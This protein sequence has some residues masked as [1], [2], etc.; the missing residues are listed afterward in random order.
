MRAQRSREDE[1]PFTPGD[2]AWRAV[3][4]AGPSWLVKELQVHFGWA[5]W[6]PWVAATLFVV[7]SFVI[8]R[9]LRARRAAKRTLPRNAGPEARAL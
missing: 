4:I 1:E 2:R 6:I 5:R 7:F 9:K 3:L 8:V